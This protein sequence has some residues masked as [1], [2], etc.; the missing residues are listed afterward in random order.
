MSW[1]NSLQLEERHKD[2]KFQTAFAEL[3]ALSVFFSKCLVLT[4]YKPP[5]VFEKA[6]SLSPLGKKWIPRI[7]KDVRDISLS[8]MN[9]ALFVKFFHHQLFI[10]VATTD[11]DTIRKTLST[12]IIRGRIRYPWIYDRLLYD[13]FFDMFPNQTEQLTYEE[14]MELLEGTPQGV[15]QLGNV[16]VGPFGAMNS[17]CQR[18]MPPTRTVPLW[19]CSDPSCQR[20]HSVGFSTG[21]SRVSEVHTFV[22]NESEEAN[23]PASE[24]GKFFL[25]LTDDHDY[26]EDMA[27]RGFPWFLINSFSKTEIQ[28]ILT[29]VISQHSKEMRQRFP[30]SGQFRDILSGSGKSISERLTKAQCFQL[31]L[32]MSDEDIADCVECLINDRVINIPYTETRTSRVTHRRSGWHEITCRCSQ[33]GIRSSSKGLNIAPARLKRL[34]KEIYRGEGE[35]ADLRWK[36]TDIDGE[37]IYEKLD[38]YIHVEDPSHIIRNLIFSNV[39]HLRRT[40]ENLRFGRFVLPSSAEEQERLIE[41]ILWKLGFDSGVYPPHQLRFWERLEKIVE[42]S[43]A[44][45]FN[46]EH[47]RELIRSAGVNLFVSLEEI[48]SYSLSFATWALLSDHYDV[49]KFKCNL[50][51]A[52]QFMATSLNGQRLGSNEPL[53]FDPNGKNTLYPLVQGFALLAR[54]CSETIEDGS[55]TLKRPK[56][57]LP[58]YHNKTEIDLF[59]FLHKVLILDLTKSD[60]D[61]MIESLQEITATLEESQVCNLRNRLEHKRLDFPDQQEIEKTCSAVTYIIDKMEKS[62]ICPLVYLYAGRTMD[63]YGRGVVTFKD[64]KGRGITI[65]QPS[66]YRLCRLPSIH[67]PQIVVPSLHINDSSELMRFTFEEI[68]DYVKMWQDYPRRKP[69]IPFKGLKDKSDSEQKQSRE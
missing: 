35:L 5:D 49:T 37:S 63:Q 21:E 23:G 50:D 33:M 60:R 9:L 40:F 46:N 67:E 56:N 4:G 44:G 41:R 24:W 42:V 28:N 25:H 47:D 43:R 65:N 62:G 38:K 53:V 30:K 39:E 31:L 64:Y 59:P 15:F 7:Q 19:H 66:Q 16:L 69:R 68:S 36:L 14:T 11:H 26:Y 18:F 34:V 45:A 22:S 29:I 2:P 8:E 10:D 3:F 58:G 13:R 12:E 17:R 52:R 27:L 61:R 48:L 51:E 57:E 6:I 20:F 32:L 1:N 54:V 55:G